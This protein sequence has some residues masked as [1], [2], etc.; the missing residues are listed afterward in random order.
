MAK[1]IIINTTM[2]T[3]FHQCEASH[4]L[5][6]RLQTVYH[7]DA[8]VQLCLTWPLTHRLVVNSVLTI[9][10]ATTMATHIDETCHKIL[11]S[12][13]PCLLHQRGFPFHQLPH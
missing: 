1:T 6:T 10:I 3:I 11:H 5:P 4:R 9:T 12:T 2:V 7:Q 8:Q 13:P